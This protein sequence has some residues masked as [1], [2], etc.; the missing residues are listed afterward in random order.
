MSTGVQKHMLDTRFSLG[1]RVL[2][3]ASAGV[4][5]GSPTVTLS[6]LSPTLGRSGDA[7]LAAGVGRQTAVVGPCPWGNWVTW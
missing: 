4:R 2:S 1:A 3:P 6:S 5:A 7:W